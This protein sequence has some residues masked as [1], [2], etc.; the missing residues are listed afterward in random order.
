[1]ATHSGTRPSRLPL[2]CMRNHRRTLNPKTLKPYIAAAPAPDC[3]ANVE[4]APPD[5]PL[6]A[7]LQSVCPSLW[8]DQ[9]G[10]A[11]RYCCTAG[12]VERIA[13]DTQKALPFIVGCPACRHNFV[14]LWCVLTCS[15]DQAAFT[16]VSAVQQAYDTNATAVAEL[17]H[18]LGR[19]YVDGMYDSCK[20][21]KFGAANVPAMSFIGG[22]ARSGPEWLAFLGTLKDK[23]FPPIGS[24]I[25]INFRPDNTT[26]G[27]MAPL[28]ER[29][30]S[31][32]DNA[33]RCSCSDCPAAQGCAQPDP[34]PPPP[35]PAC[36]V[37]SIPCL[38]FGL[39]WLYGALAA[40]VLAAFILPA[41]GRGV[42]GEQEAEGGRGVGAYA[43]A[44]EAGGRNKHDNGGGGDGDV[45]A[46]LLAG[47]GGTE[48]WDGAAAAEE[49][50]GGGGG[51]AP[52]VERLLQRG[53]YR[54][55]V[56][57]AAAAGWS[58]AGVGLLVGRHPVP[59]LAAGAALV[60]LCCCGLFWFR[61][62]TDPQRLW[63]GP[64]S[65]A[66]R[67]KAAYEA[68]FGPFYR[69]EQMIL[70]TT[71]APP[72]AAA[73]GGASR[74]AATAPAASAAAA[75][76]P[77]AAA[78]PIVSG[79]NLEL[80]FGMQRLVDELEGGS[81]QDELSR[82][83]RA[84][85][86]TV[87]A[88]YALMLAYIA[89]ALGSFPPPWRVW[90]AAR[91]SGLA[92]AGELLRSAVLTSRA[93][94]G[95]AGVAIVAASVAGALGVVSACGLWSTLI[96]ME[97][98]P[99]LALAVGVDNMFVLAHAMFKQEHTLPAPERL[100][101]ALAAAGPSVTLAA[102]CE[103]AAFGLG[104]ALT[105]MPAVRNFSLA[106][107]A[108]VG[109]DFVLQVTV[110]AALLVLDVRRLQAR[111]ADCVPCLVLPPPA[112]GQQQQQ[113]QQLQRA[114]WKAG[115]QQL[116]GTLGR[117]GPEAADAVEAAAEGPPAPDPYAP[118]AHEHDMT[119]PGGGDAMPYGGNP[120][121]YDL[122]GYD[123]IEDEEPP[124][125]GPSSQGEVDEGSY[126]SLQGLLQAYMERVHAPL[127]SLP[128]VQCGVLLAFAASLLACVAVLPY[129]Q[130]GLDQAVALPR[131]SYLQLYYQSQEYETPNA[132]AAYCPP[133]DQPPCAGNTSAC[134]SCHTCVQTAFEGGR[135]SVPQFQTYLPWFLA[136]RP[137]EQCAKAGVGAY[138]DSLQRS[139]PADPTSVAGLLPPG[140]RAGQW[141]GEGGGDGEGGGRVA[142]S[143]FRT[144]YRPLNRQADFIEA[145]RQG[146][147][148]AARASRELGL[149]V[150]AY[151]LFHVF[152]EQYLTVPYD[153]AA[154]VG[155]PLLA[156]V[157]AAAA[158]SG[159]WWAAGLLA[160]VL[161]SVL[162]HLA[163]A[164]W[165]AGIQVNAVSLVN[166]AM[167]LGIAVEF[168]AHV[169]HAFMAAPPPPPLAAAPEAGAGVAA[170]T[171]AAAPMAAPV[172]GLGGGRVERAA[173]ALRVVGASV[174]SGVTLTK[175][176]GVAVLAFARTQI[177]QVYY[178]R[179]YA[180]LVVVGAAHGLVLLPVLLALAGP[181][182]WR[183]T[184]QGRVTKMA[185]IL[186]NK[187]FA[188]APVSRASRRSAVVVRAQAQDVTRRAALGALAGAALLVSNT[189]QAS[190]S[191]GESAN[192]FGKITNKS[193]FVSY[194]GDNFSVEL[195]S[196]WNP[197]KEK[198]FPGT[199]LRYEDN[200]D[201]VNNLVVLV[202][203]S[204][205]KSIEDYGPQDKFLE[206]VSY[207]LGRQAYSGETRSEGGFAAN[208]VSAASLLDVFSTTDK[209]G[210][211]Y[212]KYELLVRSADGDEGGRHQLIAAT[213]GSD[214]KLYILKVQVGD[215][216]WF[217]GVD[218]EAKGVWNS[219]TV[220]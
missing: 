66:A 35:P 182:A 115:R 203:P 181:P 196:K 134:A 28:H 219:F 59:V 187:A 220:A 37:G 201:A 166:L 85:V 95:L 99:F 165:L 67:E 217:K 51:G 197:S 177:F 133:P 126:W 32:G 130:I 171:A 87:A 157:G 154:V 105:S 195:P 42:T 83:S 57:A 114:E 178:F 61:V 208:R 23:R 7:A 68:S 184:R 40:A 138:S 65:Q 30:V 156:V 58:P 176:V 102:V 169:L 96:I 93:S 18:W 214:S 75:S 128:A 185:T 198:D 33:F 127:L 163:G 112:R 52:L 123:M 175:L 119:Q 164:M 137:S 6:A 103:V 22:G 31:C 55:N 39:M 41:R 91:G 15:P 92:A 144:Y 209:K 84:E 106:A 160:G 69:V 205:K 113:Q 26:P 49:G 186:C 70:A 74:L 125:I 46:P 21:V 159:S 180:A 124:D 174:L 72:A 101:R 11:G 43:S 45:L 118:P 189:N 207:L 86:A 158:L 173:A 2:R 142:A 24:P 60:A 82:E 27:G 206:S 139:D 104:G 9:G 14:Q 19:E 202:Q 155:V 148:F 3:A 117:R 216:R 20:D 162:L 147:A 79:P 150:Y 149:D 215:K 53:Y 210:K 200:G 90:W 81:V 135:P 188:T 122:A 107:A 63:V 17:D 199:T 161:G 111:R 136:A 109:L 110:F 94:L 8:A 4:S 191:F 56:A 108:A 25:Q 141:A 192:V 71:A 183:A 120:L 194:A 44:A 100:A 5:A 34:A 98:I 13:S 29:A 36:R 172:V 131:D 145:M 152:F 167:A 218:K 168:C 64:A 153:A 121:L 204:D 97:V 212:Y 88:S 48:S 170:G 179:L 143:S 146:R 10:P 132:T 47:Q 129:L 12:Q 38:S 211:T 140:G 190:A 73:A 76:A 50:G 80:L 116:R 89:A 193:G 77:A 78:P 54:L 16:N 213:V 62:E 151:S 1:M